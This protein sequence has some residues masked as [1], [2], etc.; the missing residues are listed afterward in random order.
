ML[1]NRNVQMTLMIFFNLALLAAI[2]LA[3]IH[4]YNQYRAQK[5]LEKDIS[6]SAAPPPDE[7]V[8]HLD[9]EVAKGSP[10][11]FGGSHIPPPEHGDI[12]D[13]LHNVGVTMDRQD[14]AIPYSLP[15]N[16]TIEDYKSNKNNIQD[17][18]NWD[19]KT[20]DIVKKNIHTSK[21]HGLKVMGIF[22][23]APVWLTDNH[24]PN[25]VPADWDI[26]YDIIGKLYKIYRDDLDY[27]E[28]GN[29]PDHPSFL[30]VSAGDTKVAVYKQF[31]EG[32]YKTIRKVDEDAKDNKK[33]KLGAGVESNAKAS[34]ILATLLENPEMKT[35]YRPD[36][37][38][39]H[40]YDMDYTQSLD[41]YKSYSEK[42]FD[43]KMPIFVTEWNYEDRTEAS[44]AYKSGDKAMLFTGNRLVDYLNNSVAGANYFNLL[45]LNVK[46]PILGP[47]VQT[48]GFYLWN[49]NKV[50]FLPQAK[51]WRLMSRSMKLGDGASTIYK[52]DDA[53]EINPVG[54]V[55]SKGQPGI[56][57]VN[58]SFSS[59][60]IQFTFSNLPKSD[61]WKKV[62]VYEASASNDGASPVQKEIVYVKNGELSKKLYLNPNTIVG[63]LIT[64]DVSLYEKI[65]YKVLSL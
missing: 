23:Y 56:V 30:K 51:S 26:Y 43:D 55:N 29:E 64:S 60:F 38:S 39:F 16:I 24:T 13:Q 49:D 41:I 21:E 65:Q 42:Y 63:I 12:F 9:Q 61:P 4:F 47:G 31:Y 17:P 28:I 57:A 36:F 32:V 3:G 25:G 40:T 7:M 58:N 2:A 53:K 8:V 14:I 46:N 10:M 35:T 18:A 48:M 59:N 52:V 33:V 1:R 20:I 5:E 22:A 34:K 44:A 50:I 37:I 62:Y 54:F 27:V 11:V 19:H 6:A 45:P 15:R